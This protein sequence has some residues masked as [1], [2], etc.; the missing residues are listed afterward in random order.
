MKLESPLARKCYEWGG[1]LYLHTK[2]NHL[3]QIW[4]FQDCCCNWRQEHTNPIWQKWTFTECNFNLHFS[5]GCYKWGK[6]VVSRR[7]TK[8]PSSNL[9]AWSEIAALI[10]GRYILITQF[11]KSGLLQSKTWISTDCYKCGRIFENK[12]TFLKCSIRD[13]CSNWRQE[14]VFLIRQL[15]LQMLSQASKPT[16]SIKQTLVSHAEE[17]VVFYFNIYLGP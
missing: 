9:D 15:L 13:C 2:L 5:T 14:S 1:F 10:G 16:S 17:A 6:N 7:K 11:A 8:P 12:T 3:P 4:M